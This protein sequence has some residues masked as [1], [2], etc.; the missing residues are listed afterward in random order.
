MLVNELFLSIQG[1]ATS[2]GL[3]TAFVRFSGCNL[4]C[5][6]CDTTYAYDE[7][8]EMT[9]AAIYRE[10]LAF[11]PYHRACLTGGEPLLQ[12]LQELQN[13]LS[14]MA[15]WDVTIETN[16]SLSPAGLNLLPEHRLVMDLKC[17]SS[18]MAGEMHWPNLQ[19]LRRQDEIKFVISCEEDYKWCCDLIYQHQL[20]TRCHVLLSPVTAVLEPRVLV[21]WMLADRLEARFQLQMHKIIFGPLERG[22]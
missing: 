5:I 19:L 4:R 15:G 14:L 18:G 2:M 17:P 6:Y 21:S 8:R 13:L 20:T 1:E 22:V 11:H 16:G 10:L 7:G 9:S 12:P 3:P